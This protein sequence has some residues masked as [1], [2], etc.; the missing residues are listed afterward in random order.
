MPIN[1]QNQD[2]QALKAQKM[3]VKKIFLFDFLPNW[4]IMI[5]LAKVFFLA[6]FGL[7]T[8]KKSIKAIKAKISFNKHSKMG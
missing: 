1:K 7:L 5:L 2:Q 6:F 4:A 8:F 3:F